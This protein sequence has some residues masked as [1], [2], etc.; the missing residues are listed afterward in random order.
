MSE[1]VAQHLACPCCGENHMDEL[2]WSSGGGLVKCASCG[3]I[4]DP[5]DPAA[6][7]DPADWDKDN[8]TAA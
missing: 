2:V 8:Q 3:M 5:N 7:F 6:S 4:Y 1:T